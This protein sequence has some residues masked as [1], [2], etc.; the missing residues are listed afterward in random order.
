MRDGTAPPDTGG[1][2]AVARAD[3]RTM[4]TTS[5]HGTGGAVAGNQPTGGTPPEPRLLVVDDEPNI[6][7]LLSASLRYAGFEVAT[8][9]NGQ[10][11]LEAVGV[12][13]AAADSVEEAVVRAR[14]AAAGES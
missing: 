9:T 12:A 8:A 3:P 13:L 11:A 7:E 4:T 5:V 10:E 14:T 2:Q 6:R 1:T